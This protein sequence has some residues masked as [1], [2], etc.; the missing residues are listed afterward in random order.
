M[1]NLKALSLIESSPA[2]KKVVDQ[3]KA[4]ANEREN[5]KPLLIAGSRGT[6]KKTLARLF[7]EL[8]PQK[9]G[10]FSIMNMGSSNQD[11]LFQ[12]GTVNS[13]TETLVIDQAE[14]L[15]TFEYFKFLNGSKQEPE[16][17]FW[18][19]LLKKTETKIEREQLIF[20]VPPLQTLSADFLRF[21]DQLNP[22]VI[23]VPNLKETPEQIEPLANYFMEKL[24][25]YLTTPK[26]L[27]P[28]SYELLRKHD[29]PGNIR[30][31]KNTI[32]RSH[33]NTFNQE[34]NPENFIFSYPLRSSEAQILNTSPMMTMDE[35]KIA[36]VRNALR[37]TK[38][39]KRQAALALNIT[40]NTLGA[41]I[42]QGNINV[43]DYKE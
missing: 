41:Y 28:A 29:W 1:I 38:G 22:R 39:N 23:T 20:I 27:T 9:D 25:Q 2:F 35:G 5:L 17:P 4:W 13:S 30:E 12:T 11:H 10:C 21:Y 18:K 31:L 3:L 7:H 37:I 14:K 19:K 42:I 40:I 16:I 32:K 34:I 33:A 8:S 43:D 24:N 15:S 36:I 26:I 6:G